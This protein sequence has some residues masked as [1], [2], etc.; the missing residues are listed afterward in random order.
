MEMTNF[1]QKDNMERERLKF[2]IARFD[3]YFDSINNKGTVFLGL[4]TF[5]IGGL[6]AAYPFFL[7]SISCTLAV[8][9]LMFSMLMIGLV[10]MTIVILATT[11]FLSNDK[12]SL[13]YFGSICCLT[14]EEFEEKSLGLDEKGDLDDLRSQAH[15]LSKG[16]E[17]KFQ[18]LRTAGILFLLQFILFI[19]LIILLILSQQ[20]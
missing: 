15:H 3:H 11:P 8:N 12:N 9:I 18:R 17:S 5:M 6:V 1:H 16:L 13:L 20:K 19:P 2:C 14:K 7:G 10:I 4:E